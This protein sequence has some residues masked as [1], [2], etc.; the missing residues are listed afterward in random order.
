MFLS[1]QEGKS[2]L[3]VQLWGHSVSFGNEAVVPLECRICIIYL[4]F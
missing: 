1:L 3:G 4:R 2:R